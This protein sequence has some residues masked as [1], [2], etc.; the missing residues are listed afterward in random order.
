[1]YQKVYLKEKLLCE[2]VDK[3][4]PSFKEL[5]RMG[6]ILDKTLKYFTYKFKKATNLGKS[7]LCL[8]IHK[9]L[10]NFPERPIT[11]NCG[12]PTEKASEFLDFHLKTIMQNGASCIKDSNDF[13][14]KM[15]NIDISNNALL[16]TADVVGFSSGRFNCTQRNFG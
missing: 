5:K 6:C 4:N 9:R 16:V 1:M 8:K 12:D 14:S 7:D 3:S 15:K 10:E 13:K 11:S 2:L